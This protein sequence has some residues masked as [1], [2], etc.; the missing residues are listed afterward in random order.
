MTPELRKRAKAVNF[1]IMYGISAFGLAKDIGVSKREADEYIKHYMAAYPAISEYLKNV[2]T[3][4]KRD[5]YVS[6][7]YGRRRYIPEINSSKKMLVS[8]AERVARNTPIQGAAADII[9]KAMVDTAETLK[10]AGLRSRLILQI[11]DELIVEAPE[12]EK[13]QAAAILRS[14]MEN[15]FPLD[16]PLTVDMTEGKSWEQ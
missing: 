4:A 2:V 15:A 13:E 14:C 10:K 5:G 12:N 9:K 11:H 3:D 1:G 16:V 6:T 8:F 7:I